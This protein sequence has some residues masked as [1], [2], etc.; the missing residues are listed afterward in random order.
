MRLI[1]LSYA[2]RD[3]KE[4]MAKDTSCYGV[5]PAKT[6]FLAG[7]KLHM[8]TSYTVREDSLLLE[9]KEIEFGD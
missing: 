2:I 1:G 9:L 8:I 7:D 5:L 6:P 4:L 3:K